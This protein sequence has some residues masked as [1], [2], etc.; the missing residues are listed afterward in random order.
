MTELGRRHSAVLLLVLV[1]CSVLVY[2]GT[3]EHELLNWDDRSYVSNNPWVTNPN[4]TNIAA[5][6][7][8]S[9][10]A[11]WHPLTWLSY[12]PEYA[13]CG[14]NASCYKFNNALLHGLNGFLVAILVMLSAK[15]LGATSSVALHA[16]IRRWPEL[17]VPVLAGAVAGFLF[18]VHPQRVESVT[19]VAER[20]DLL[21]ALFYFAA[22]IVYLQAD[23]SSYL[24]T[25]GWC[26]LLFVLALMSKSMAIRAA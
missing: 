10:M 3:S 23:R 22:L 11:N 6:F 26:L 8:D 4:P 9:R 17:S 1:A 16:S 2:S 7:T 5:M 19:W 25:Y 18:V 15:H 13:L 14:D 12:V 24:E 20:K 21:C